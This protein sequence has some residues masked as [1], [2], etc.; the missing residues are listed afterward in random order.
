MNDYDNLMKRREELEK[1]VKFGE[2]VHKLC[3]SKEFSEVIEQEVGDYIA[4]NPTQ[5]AI[6]EARTALKL[7]RLGRLPLSGWERQQVATVQIADRLLKA[8]LSDTLRVNR[9]TNYKC[10]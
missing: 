10:W 6:Q 2:S 7:H 9:K 8:V 3:E 4:A 1:I 5:E